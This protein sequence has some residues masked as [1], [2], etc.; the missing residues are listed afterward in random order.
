M[1]TRARPAG[2]WIPGSV[3]AQAEIEHLDDYYL[4]VDGAAGGTY[5]PTDPIVIGGDGVTLAGVNHSLTGTLAV[6]SGA[7][8][9]IADGGK[10]KA[11]GGGDDIELAVVSGVGTLDVKSGAYVKIEAGGS[12]DV[13]GALAL[14]SGGSFNVE[15]GSTETI[16]SGG[17]LTA[18]SGSTTNLN[19]ATAVR[20]AMTLKSTAN[21][22]PGSI[23][24]EVD[25]IM[26]GV[27][28]MQAI[29]DCTSSAGRIKWRFDTLTDASQTI[30]IASKTIVRL[31]NT[32]AANRTII[33]ST[34]IGTP[35]WGDW[36][37]VFRSTPQ[38]GSIT[39][40]GLYSIQLE[41][42]TGDVLFVWPPTSDKR[43]AGVLI[44]FSETDGDWVPVFWNNLGGTGTGLF[45][46]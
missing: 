13:Y 35:K 7:I 18:A 9:S 4:A 28:S 34:S 21:G 44:V 19:G 31:N 16:N 20:G 23:T 15:S 46:E 10:I 33:V 22:G 38:S 37:Y 6:A 43:R 45:G 27:F 12:Q 2:L 3:I 26:A 29:L 8:I 11:D 5:A 32:C 39:D 24:G 14:K 42:D 41:S 17:I 25:T 36:M 1:F 40:S 30:S